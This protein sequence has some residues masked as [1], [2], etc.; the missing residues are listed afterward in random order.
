MNKE[1]KL[2]QY[3]LNDKGVDF[4]PLGTSAAVL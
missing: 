2:M 3:K 1:T 4:F